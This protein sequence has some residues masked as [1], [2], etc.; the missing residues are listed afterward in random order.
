MKQPENVQI[1]PKKD[2]TKIAAPAVDVFKMFQRFKKNKI[3]R[4][5]KRLRLQKFKMIAI[6]KAKRSAL[7]AK[8]R[9][10]KKKWRRQ[11]KDVRKLNKPKELKDTR[12]Y[13]KNLRKRFRKKF[14]KIR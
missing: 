10:Q 14:K 13:I 1:Q 9:E 8:W 3:L 7:I 6:A 5:Q 2:K 4:A 12:S 11:G